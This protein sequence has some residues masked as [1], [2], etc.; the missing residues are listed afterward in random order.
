MAK[1]LIVD[2]E[3]MIREVIREYAEVEGYEIR[4]AQN[5]I[6]AI[7]WCKKEEFDAIIMDVMMP[8]IDGFTTYEKIRKDKKIPVLI[9][10]AKGQEYDKLYG[11]SLGIDDYIVKP[12]SP[13][14]LMARLLVV[15]SRNKNKSHQICLH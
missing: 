9:L 8:G 7:E 3:A 1:I 5:G 12:F 10:S 14:E 11:F 15:L 2:D 13:K 6:Q 4:E